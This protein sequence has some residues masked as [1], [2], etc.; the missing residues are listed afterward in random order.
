[1]MGMT[2]QMFLVMN[3]MAPSVMCVQ[4]RMML[5]MPASWSSWEKYF[6]PAMTAKLVTSGGTMHA[7][8]TAAMKAV[9]SA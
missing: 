4:P 9:P 1:M 7:A 2:G 3:G 6:L 5:T 8:E